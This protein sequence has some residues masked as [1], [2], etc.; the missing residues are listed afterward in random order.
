[1]LNSSLD[2][3]AS[4]LLEWGGTLSQLQRNPKMLPLSFGVD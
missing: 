4:I 1:V 3:I 2:A